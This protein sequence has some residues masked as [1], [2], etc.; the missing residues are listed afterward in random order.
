MAIEMAMHLHRPVY[1]FERNAICANIRSGKHYRL[2]MVGHFNRHGASRSENGLELEG[3]AVYLA[4]QQGCYDRIL[5]A[6]PYR[7]G[8]VQ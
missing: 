2:I 3:F 8:M 1:S 6:C 7:P 4:V 5:N